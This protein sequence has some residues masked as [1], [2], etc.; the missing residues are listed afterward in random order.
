MDAATR[1]GRRSQNDPVGNLLFVLF[2]FQES[3]ENSCLYINISV[4][5]LLLLL[6]RCSEC[7]TP[8]TRE[9][10]FPKAPAVCLFFRAYIQE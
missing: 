5:M 9:A 4:D 6:L 1:A 3:D 2:C 7:L 10:T 8:C